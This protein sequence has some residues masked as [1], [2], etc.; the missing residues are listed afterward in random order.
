[1][2]QSNLRI[3]GQFSERQSY[4]TA[5]SDS[6]PMHTM[7]IETVT[8]CSQYLWIRF[9]VLAH[10]LLFMRKRLQIAFQCSNIKMCVFA[11]Q[12]RTLQ[13]FESKNHK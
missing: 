1:V 5:S 11:K 7:N 8:S 10:V 2:F 3:Y 4:F 13:A 9:V 6:Y 12:E